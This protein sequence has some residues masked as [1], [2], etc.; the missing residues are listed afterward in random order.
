MNEILSTITHTNSK[1]KDLYMSKFII[2]I[3]KDKKVKGKD[4]R[5]VKNNKF[6]KFLKLFNIHANLH[7]ANNVKKYATMMNLN[8]LT[9]EL[10]HKLFTLFFF[11][12]K[13]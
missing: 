13:D 1:T 10:K 3:I 7:F 2:I 9:E 5:K 12:R 6:E 8:V 4:K 11:Y